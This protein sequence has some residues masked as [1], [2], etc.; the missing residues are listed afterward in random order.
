MNNHQE[1]NRTAAGKADRLCITMKED[2]IPLF[3]PL[4]Q[5]GVMLKVS[6]GCSVRSLLLDQLEIPADYIEGRIQTIFIDGKPVDDLDRVAIRDGSTLALSSALPGLLGATL[7]RGGYYAALRSQIT[8]GEDLGS[9]KVRNGRITLKLF[10][11]TL[12]EL[13]PFFLE[14][15]I[16]LDAE[17]LADFFKRPTVDFRQGCEDT[18][19]NGEKIDPAGLRDRK[20]KAGRVYLQVK[21]Y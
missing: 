18:S 20:W 5:K 7:R 6:V 11:L 13:G 15:G 1:Y 19:L 21:R 2:L 8:H 10:N 17:D 4:L 9:F 12:K 3:F 16:W 14:R